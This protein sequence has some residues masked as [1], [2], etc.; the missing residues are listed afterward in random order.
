MQQKQRGPP[1]ICEPGGHVQVPAALRVVGKPAQLS[2]RLVADTDCTYLPSNNVPT[3]SAVL[4]VLGV[5]RLREMVTCEN[6]LISR[7]LLQA[8]SIP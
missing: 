2:T 6:I 4:A 3:A 8:R 7:S 1:L 5:P